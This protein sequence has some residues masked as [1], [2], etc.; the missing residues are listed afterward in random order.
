MHTVSWKRGDLLEAVGL[1]SVICVDKMSSEVTH[2]ETEE[3][4]VHDEGV[5]M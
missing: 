3:E 5:G 1:F 4:A 2:T